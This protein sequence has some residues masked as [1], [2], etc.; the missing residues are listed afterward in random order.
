MSSGAFMCHFCLLGSSDIREFLVEKLKVKVS[1]VRLFATPWNSSGQ[2]IGVDS[3][4][5]QPTPVFFLENP[6][7]GGA[8]RAAVYGATQSWIRLKWLSSSSLSLLQGIPRLGDGT[9]V[10]CIAGRFFTSWATRE[11]LLVESGGPNPQKDEVGQVLSRIHQ[12]RIQKTVDI[13]ICINDSLCC[14]PEVSTIL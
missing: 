3:L 11:A 2:N 4:S 13:C 14:T 10:F 12:K 7:D 8:W 1:P 5:L 6:R 9:Q